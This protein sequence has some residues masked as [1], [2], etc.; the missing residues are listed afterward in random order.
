MPAP[1]R[2]VRNLRHPA[3][4]HEDCFDD[5]DITF[6]ASLYLQLACVFKQC[7]KKAV[8]TCYAVYR[9]VRQHPVGLGVA[10]YDKEKRDYGQPFRVPEKK[11]IE[12]LFQHF[13]RLDPILL[14]PWSEVVAEFVSGTL[15]QAHGKTVFVHPVIKN[16]LFCTNQELDISVRKTSGAGCAKGGNFWCYDYAK[17]A[18]VAV[19][20]KSKCLKCLTEYSLQTYSPGGYILSQLGMYT[21]ISLR[22]IHVLKLHAAVFMDGWYRITQPM[23]VLRGPRVIVFFSSSCTTSVTDSL[24]LVNACSGFVQI[25]KDRLL[26]TFCFQSTCNI[27]NGSKQVQRLSLTTTFSVN[28]TA[29][30][31]TVLRRVLKAS[32][33]SWLRNGGSGSETDPV[34][35]VLPILSRS[36]QVPRTLQQRQETGTCGIL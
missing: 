19:L 13:S 30:K 25:W 3:H 24:P 28:G 2:L 26:R 5:H 17:G 15:T 10:N 32:L 14:R 34:L 1:A 9:S 20:F 23:W 4:N 31:C 18:Q 27:P 36:R 11:D 6:F 12:R 29:K 22:C 8:A 16:C 35:Y 33:T 7:P 21:S